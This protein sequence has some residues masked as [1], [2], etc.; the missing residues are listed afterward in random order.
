MYKL[1]N[2]HCMYIVHSLYS[3]KNNLFLVVTFHSQSASVII[4]FVDNLS[5]HQVPF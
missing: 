2:V 4:N 5:C 1:V 3:V